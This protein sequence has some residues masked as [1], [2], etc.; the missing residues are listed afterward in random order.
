MSNALASLRQ[1]ARDRP[2]LV[3]A[4]GFCNGDPRTTVLAHFRLAGISGIGL[5]SPD[6]IAAHCC[7]SC[8]DLIDGRV[9]S[10]NFTR[11]EVQRMHLD[12]VLRT[13]VWWLENGFISIK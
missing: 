10:P 1:S 12:G 5:K 13:Q 4:P 8:H 11:A 9:R 7:S 2:C 6:L 3:R